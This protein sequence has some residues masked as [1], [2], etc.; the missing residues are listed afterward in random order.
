MNTNDLPAGLP[1]DSEN[2]ERPG[3]PHILE[4][5]QRISACLSVTDLDASVLWYTERMGFEEV[6]RRDFPDLN[7]RLAYVRWGD[8]IL[9]L[10]QSTPSVG[11][12]RPAPPAG[13]TIVRGIT[14]VSLHVEDAQKAMEQVK[15]AGLP[16]LTDLIDAA[17][18]G[19]KA[20][21]SQDPDGNLIEFHQADW[22]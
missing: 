4:G 7:A 13:H 15:E 20:F 22:A 17:P 18:I 21:F 5:V 3:R 14:Q 1:A 6:L 19:V 2:P 8:L 9:E 16:L 11:V 10:V 12:S